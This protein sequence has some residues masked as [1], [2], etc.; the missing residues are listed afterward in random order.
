VLALCAGLALGVGAVLFVVDQRGADAV[1]RLR[2]PLGDSEPIEVRLILYL[3][4]GAVWGTGA[5]FFRL[6]Y[7]LP[8][9]GS[10]GAGLLLVAALLMFLG[11]L[12]F[13]YAA[14]GSL[15]QAALGTDGRPPFWFARYLSWFDDLVMDA[16]DMMARVLVRPAGAPTRTAGRARDAEVPFEAES[17]TPESVEKQPV[18]TQPRR[19]NAQELARE[20]L[21]L[22]LE[23]YEASLTAGQKDKLQV[24]RDIVEWI[25]H[26]FDGG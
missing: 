26:A 9:E 5:L 15:L 25:R 1:I 17:I 7:M 20:R 8:P 3:V 4:F 10:N 13:F 19:R 11:N 14:L 24:M 16:G 12:T 21:E 22:A 6:L 23:Q 2:V 18:A